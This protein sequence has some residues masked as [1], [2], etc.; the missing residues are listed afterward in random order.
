[1]R[2]HWG[3]RSTVRSMIAFKW[4]SM[5]VAYERQCALAQ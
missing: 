3:A 5:A 4:S 1:L 2:S